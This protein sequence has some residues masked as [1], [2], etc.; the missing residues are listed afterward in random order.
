MPTVERIIQNEIRLALAPDAV[1]F[2]GNIGTAWTGDLVTKLPNGDMLIKNARPF[3]SGLPAGFS[4][5]FGLTGAGT[6]VAIEVKSPQGRLTD[7]QAHFLDFIAGR[8][9]ISGVARSV[10][11][12]RR[13]LAGK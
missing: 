9:G 3:N 8:G 12:A 2:R 11:E 7:K 5:L 1:L 6:F 13:L 10:D 4:D